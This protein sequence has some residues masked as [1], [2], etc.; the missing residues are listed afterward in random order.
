MT[1]LTAEKSAMPNNVPDVPD[2]VL[3]KKTPAMVAVAF[4]A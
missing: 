1:F 2:V 3:A 4:S